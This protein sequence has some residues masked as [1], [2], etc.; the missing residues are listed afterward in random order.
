MF[1]AVTVYSGLS[2]AYGSGWCWP[3]RKFG[4]PA[5]AAE[6]RPPSHAGMEPSAFAAF[7]AP[8]GVSSLPSLAASVAET[9]ARTGA[10]ATRPASETRPVRRCFW[11]WF[12]M[13]CALVADQNEY[14]SVAAT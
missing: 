11:I 8:S 10:P 2:L 4:K 1:A 7:S 3:E 6:V 5:C 12:F 14:F 13:E 9:A